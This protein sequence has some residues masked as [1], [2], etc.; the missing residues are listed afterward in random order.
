[1]HA[2]TTVAMRKARC[3]REHLAFARRDKPDEPDLVRCRSQAA[4]ARQLPNLKNIP[5]LIISSDDA[6][7]EQRRHR[8]RHRRLAQRAAAQ[9]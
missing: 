3:P 4:P 5:I 6:G 8:R 7:E 9:G 2:V 1:L